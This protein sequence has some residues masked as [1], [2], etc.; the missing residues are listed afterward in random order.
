MVPHQQGCGTIPGK[1]ERIGAVKRFL[2]KRI[3]MGLLILLGVVTIT[4]FV[5]RVLPSDPA[6]QWVG[7][8]ATQEQLEK[9]R[10]ELG[11]DRPLTEQYCNYISDLLQGN[12]GTS[13]RTKRSVL[14]DLKT[15]IP[16]TIELVL[17]ATVAAFIIGIPLGVYSASHK[18]RTLDHFCRVMSVASVSIPTFTVALLLQLIFY[19]NLGWLPLGGQMDIKISMLHNVPH[20]TGLL[21]LDC[22][23]A[24]NMVLF[25][26][27]LRHIILPAFTISLYPIGLIARMTRSALVEILSEDYIKAARSYGLRERLVLWKYAVKNSLGTTMNVL[28]LCMGYALVN[29]FLVEAIF[30]WPGI[31]MYIAVAVTTLD[32]PAIIGVT[33][34]SAFAYVI[35]NMIADMVIAIDPRVRL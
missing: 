33:I 3:L 30:S 28:V 13:L 10:G 23:I 8:R 19:Q 22:L 17:V 14:S 9:A 15:Y 35:L 7:I 20:Y 6:R 1:R 11:L 31:G 16:P 24:G 4:F 21:L 2:L 26:D 32:Y 29:T 12:L 18:D 34:F 25:K 27:A 5:S